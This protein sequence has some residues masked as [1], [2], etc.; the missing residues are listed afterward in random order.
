MR[1]ALCE[2]GGHKISRELE[3][4]KPDGSRN[5]TTAKFQ[6]GVKLCQTVK[7]SAL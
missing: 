3:G 2:Q 7:M 6:Q 5:L 4:R 1:V